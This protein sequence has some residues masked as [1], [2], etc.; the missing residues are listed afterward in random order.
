[1]R[2][3]VIHLN[4][5]KHQSNASFQFHQHQHQTMTSTAAD[6]NSNNGT[7]SSGQLKLQSEEYAYNFWCHPDLLYDGGVMMMDDHHHHH[8]H[9]NHHTAD[10]ILDDILDEMDLVSEDHHHH[11]HHVHHH[12]ESAT[13][14]RTRRT[15]N[16]KMETTT[17][18]TTT[19]TATAT[20]TKSIYH[21]IDHN[22]MKFV[23]FDR[24]SFSDKIPEVACHTSRLEVAETFDTCMYDSEEYEQR[25]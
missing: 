10:S 22:I 3:K 15:A 20:A 16:T 8:H 11:H 24:S 14:T 18:A 5:A 1:M 4:S 13:A 17:S 23:E 7:C 12:Q 21:H 2:S 19:T 6:N 25:L 9:H